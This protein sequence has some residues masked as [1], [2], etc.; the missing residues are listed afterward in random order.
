MANPILEQARKLIAEGNLNEAESVLA[1]SDK[2]WAI[3]HRADLILLRTP[4]EKARVDEAVQLYEQ[5]ARDFPEIVP[6]SI[7][8]AKAWLEAAPDPMMETLQEVF[9]KSQFTKIERHL[10]DGIL[11]GQHTLVSTTTDTDNSLLYEF[12]ACIVE[13]KT[14]LLTTRMMKEE[15][16]VGT[17]RINPSLSTEEAVECIGEFGGGD[18]KVLVLGPA[19][20][21][22]S[23]V[24]DAVRNLQ[25]E[26]IVF[27]QAQ[28]C[29]ERSPLFTP[30]AA[31]AAAGIVKLQAP[32]IL[33]LSGIVPPHVQTNIGETLKMIH[34]ACHTGPFDREELYWG[35]SKTT[36]KGNTIAA[37][38]ASSSGDAL[39]FAHTPEN[40]GEVAAALQEQGISTVVL[41]EE[42]DSVE[43]DRALRNWERTEARVMVAQPILEETIK[44]EIRNIFYSDYPASL[45]EFF[46]NA[47]FAG[48][49]GDPA[50]IILLYES[51]DK[52][53]HLETFDR[54][55]PDRDHLEKT[56]EAMRA[57]TGEESLNPIAIEIL[58]KRGYLRKSPEGSW[59]F[60][61]KDTPIQRLDLSEV[62]D[63]RKLAEERLR[64][65]E[66][67]AE[68]RTCR[69]RWIL[70][71]FGA[72]MPGKWKCG[73]C[74][75]CRA[76]ESG[77]TK[78]DPEAKEAVL[79]AVMELESR[80]MTI[81]G[82]ARAIM[83]L[84]RPMKGLKETD[85]KELLHVLVREGDL[86]LNP[87]DWISIK[88]R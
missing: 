11:K 17:F 65:M 45:E 14:I 78:R 2:P 59:E 51:S 16:A 15:P 63:R 74:D 32:R 79:D 29:C 53:L 18:D 67:Y 36:E 6:A 21:S 56:H 39:V 38:L 8:R 4:F 86:E 10:I 43:R 82:M 57:G 64:E 81:S 5:V 73:G 30:E 19:H 80:R 77:F 34:P 33:A 12:P 42:M 7:E 66:E 88:R 41:H 61:E 62:E 13:G 31:A 37:A 35:V 84:G 69:R 48:R 68:T 52:V 76:L 58:V 85:I 54:L 27:D 23:P 9:E 44:T 87:G 22:T 71:H 49:D 83:F 3:L 46:E 47:M 60:P 1:Q 72:K 20:F 40:V 26:L 55:Y 50:S 25:I 24:Q 70:E 28:S 75:R